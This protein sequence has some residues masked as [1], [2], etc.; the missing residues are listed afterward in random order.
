MSTK[1]RICRPRDSRAALEASL[2]RFL[3]DQGGKSRLPE[4][5][6]GGEVVKTP[7]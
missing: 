2:R 7:R 1:V 5:P 3:D 6:A 4:P